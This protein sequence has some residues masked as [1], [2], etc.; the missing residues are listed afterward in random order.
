MTGMPTTKE[1]HVS[2]SN[3]NEIIAFPPSSDYFNLTILTKLKFVIG[4][5]TLKIMTVGGQ[6]VAGEKRC[7]LLDLQKF[8]KQNIQ[9]LFALLQPTPTTFISLSCYEFTIS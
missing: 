2:P 3:I 8:H 7:R 6:I 1:H 4:H 9:E 5:K